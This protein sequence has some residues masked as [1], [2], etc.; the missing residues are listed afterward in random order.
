M[1]DAHSVLDATIVEASAR[2][3]RDTAPKA[4]ESYKREWNRF[5]MFVD[6]ARANQ[7]LPP[8]NKYLARKMWTFSS[9]LLLP[10]AI[11]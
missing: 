4:D 6:N 11:A 10:F 2:N 9:P 7:Q 5:R 8:G 3:V 1:T